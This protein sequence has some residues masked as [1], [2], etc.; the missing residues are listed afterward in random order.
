MDTFWLNIGL[1][2]AVLVVVGM[3]LKYLRS[4]KRSCDACR[5]EQH[6]LVKNHITHSTDAMMENAK[7]TNKLRATMERFIDKLDGK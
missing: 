4:V 5:K 2:G 1:G 3:F 6:D 7:A